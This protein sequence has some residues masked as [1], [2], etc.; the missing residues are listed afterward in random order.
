MPPPHSRR[1]G[2]EFGWYCSM[3]GRCCSRHFIYSCA[4]AGDWWCWF[5]SWWAVCHGRSAPCLVS[6]RRC[7]VKRV[8]CSGWK[9]KCQPLTLLNKI[10]RMACVFNAAAGRLKERNARRQISACCWKTRR[11][12][13]CL[14]CIR[15]HCAWSFPRL[16]CPLWF[17]ADWP[18]AGQKERWRSLPLF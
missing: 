16:R 8:R 14:A 15:E 18:E 6:I 5:F 12:C 2:I 13:R 1:D 4:G 11:S 3:V 17:V 9:W 10:S 7:Q